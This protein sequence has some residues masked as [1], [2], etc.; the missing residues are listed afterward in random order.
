MCF[1]PNQRES[2]QLARE[3]L[4]R[5]EERKPTEVSRP[6]RGNR[7]PDREELR[8]AEQRLLSVVGN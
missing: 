8:R 5:R 1:K 6:P 4:S 2:R 7:K 3:M